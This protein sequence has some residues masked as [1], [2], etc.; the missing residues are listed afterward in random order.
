[1]DFRS[2]VE[3][4]ELLNSLAQSKRQSVLIEGSVGCGKSYL[5]RQYATMLDISDVVTVA[6]KVNDLKDAIDSCFQTNNNI[7]LCIENLD[8]GVAGASYTILKFLEEPV[9]NVYIVVTCRNIKHIPDT[10]ISRSAT[11][12]VGP[13]TMQDI[14]DY[15][16]LTNLE[17]YQ[18]VSNTLVWKCARSFS[19][20]DA[21]LKMNNDEIAYYQD[22]SKVCSFKDSVSNSVWNISHYKHNNQDCN[23]EL[24]IRSIIEIA[25]NP[26]ITRCGVE[27]INELNQ[28]RIAKHAILSKFM[29]NAKYCE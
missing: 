21:I 17:A 28:G 6:P 29:F 1:M 13:P 8:L 5:A 19:D 10:I 27:C 9:Y 20:A 18:R 14:T 25:H 26:F 16:K 11:V 22:L 3:P 15:A 2:Q 24:S 4:L 7:L 12:T 23:L